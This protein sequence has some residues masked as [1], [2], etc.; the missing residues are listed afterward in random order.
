[1]AK[2]ITV[3]NFSYKNRKRTVEMPVEIYLSAEFR[4]YF[5]REQIHKEFLDFFPEELGD[6]HNRFY[7]DTHKELIR[8]MED[9]IEKF[10]AAVAD[11]TKEKIILYRMKLNGDLTPDLSGSDKKS[12][13]FTDLDLGSNFGLGLE[14]YLAWKCKRAGKTT[15]HDYRLR[16][17][18]PDADGSEEVGREVSG[19]GIGKKDGEQVMPWTQQREDWFKALEESLRRMILNVDEFFNQKSELLIDVIDQNKTLRLGPARKD[20]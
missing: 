4:F 17:E 8:F 6:Y 5:Q 18:G 19:W 16:D 1:M 13:R 12:K 15:Y 2:K 7:F 14:W 9:L 11:N 20:E 10:E 3:R